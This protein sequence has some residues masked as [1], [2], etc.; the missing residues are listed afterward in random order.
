MTKRTKIAVLAAF[1]AAAAVVA[2]HAVAA[3]DKTPSVEDIM[4]KVNKRKAG[5]HDQ[6]KE[7]LK[8]GSPDWAAVQK[9]TKEYSALAD[10]LG[11]NDPP[12]GDKASWERMTKAY[13][14]NAKKLN[15]AAEKKDLSGAQASIDAL[16]K[17]CMGC[18]RAHRPMK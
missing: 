5:L 2:G 9:E 16:S 7:A 12:K 8:G 10:F 3:D 1:V 4:K 6:V 11:K 18:H 14:A 13:A 15:E 17:S